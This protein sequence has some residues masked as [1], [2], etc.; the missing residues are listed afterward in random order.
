MMPRSTFGTLGCLC[1]IVFSGPAA[2]QIPV[3]LYNSGGFE[4]PRFAPGD[5]TNQDPAVGPNPGSNPLVGPWQ[6]TLG[7]TATATVQ[8]AVVN[9]GLQSVRVDRPNNPANVDSYWAVLKNQPATP[10][11]VTINWDMFLP[12]PASSTT[13]PFGPYFAVAAFYDAGPG[14]GGVKRIASA[15][16]DATTGEFLYQRHDPSPPLNGVIDVSAGDAVLAFN[17]WHTFQMVLNYDG[18]GGGTFNVSVDSVPLA[19]SAFIDSGITSLTDAPIAA[20]AA[21]GDP[22]SQAAPGTGYFD[23]FSVTYTTPVPEPS[24]IALAGLGVAGLVYRRLRRAAVKA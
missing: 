8:G 9:G 5:L 3:V 19:A 21:G 23:N 18:L 4:P 14:G 13:P 7:A 1:L 22:A 10:Q 12:A 2:A 11:T 20:I 24:S 6:K 16:M 15:G 17:A